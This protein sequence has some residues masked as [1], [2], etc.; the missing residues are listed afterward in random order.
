MSEYWIAP[1]VE[2][3]AKSLIPKHHPHLASARIGYLFREK[4]A[5]RKVTLDGS[6][7]RV[8]QGQAGRIGSRK[9]E[10]LC[11]KDFVIEIAADEWQQASDAMR[12]YIVDH[13]LSH[14]GGEED[15]EK[16]GEMVWFMIPHDIEEFIG[17][18]E[19]NGL[20]RETVRDFFRACAKA[21]QDEKKRL[22]G[23]VVREAAE[24]EPANPSDPS[25]P[26]DATSTDDLLDAPLTVE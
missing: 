13:E 26:S 17:V 24:A 15:P 1:E 21:D 8:T 3:I 11:E 23:T 10:V 14:C 19:R 18:V 22:Y 20:Q 9:Y 2:E 7:E 16:G 4:A 25:D 12:R 5:R 6:I